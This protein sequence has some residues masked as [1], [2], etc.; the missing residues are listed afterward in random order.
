MAAPYF[1]VNGVDIL[2]FIKE[3]GLKW[4][5]NDVDSSKSGRTM[6]A[7]MRR[8]RVAIKYRWDVTIRP[9]KTDEINMIT[10]LIEPVFVDIE[11]NIDPRHGH[12]YHSFY[13]NN[14]P[15]TCVTIDPETGIAIWNEFSF[16]LIEQ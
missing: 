2:P 12:Y 4:Q 10:A 15:A 9:L 5:R 3:G 6:D 7:T 8:S 1:K 16:P 11:T 13:S 14:V